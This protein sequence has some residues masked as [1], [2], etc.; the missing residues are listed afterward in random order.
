MFN[1]GMGEITVILLLALIVLGP[2]KLPELA[3]GLGKIIRDIR[4]ATNDVKNE[5]QLDEHIR[6]PFE[7]L[8]DAVTLHPEELK[9][10]D[11]LKKDLEE[12]RKRAEADLAALSKAESAADGVDA[13]G[14]SV[15]AA[16]A[17]TLPLP[18]MP[19]AVSPPPPFPGAGSGAH[20][21]SPVPPPFP[22]AGSGPHASSPIP[23]PLAPGSGS[24]P[25]VPGGLPPPMH[26]PTPVATL[27]AAA[28]AGHA[29]PP[30]TVPV[31]SGRAGETARAVPA[32]ARA[33]RP[34]IAAA[35]PVPAPAPKPHADK[36]VTTQ[37]L[38]EADLIPPDVPPPLPAHIPG[39]TGKHA[40]PPPAPGT[41]GGGPA[42]AAGENQTADAAKRAPPD[43]RDDKQE[44]KKEDKKHDVS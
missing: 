2:K 44:D 21:S 39:S 9:R 43:S 7:E 41:A 15:P 31:G 8:R 40:H 4:K 29:H 13:D 38:S 1:L 24:G 42:A 32:A 28:A 37:F 16:T 6:K 35:S 11:Q 33:P 26:H 20:A 27:H 19:A 3:S 22:G 14:N 18:G 36:T 25:Q 34:P 12:A 10:R 23:S 17:G 30:H 5:I